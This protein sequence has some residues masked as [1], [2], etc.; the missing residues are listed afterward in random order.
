MYGGCYVI[1]ALLA[2]PYKFGHNF[3][4]TFRLLQIKKVADG[5]RFGGVSEDLF[6]EVEEIDMG[7][8]FEGSEDGGEDF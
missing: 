5:E 8:D 7:G 4:V 1:A 6:E 2:R 3:G